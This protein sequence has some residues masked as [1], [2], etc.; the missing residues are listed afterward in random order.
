MPTLEDKEIKLERTRQWRIK[1]KSYISEYNKNYKKHNQD[2][3]KEY[4]Q[5][6]RE[7]NIESEKERSKKYHQTNPEVKRKS[8][9]KSR[10]LIS[11]EEYELLLKNQNYVCAICKEPESVKQKT[12]GLV[13]SLAV[14]HC[15]ISGKVRGLLCFRC[16]ATLGKIK[17]DKKLL[18]MMIK[19]LE[20]EK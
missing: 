9:R 8:I 20:S 2:S 3:I 4:N 18:K 1:N 16:N 7:N 13:K 10:Y 5:K 12:T 17:E 19:Y 11:N 15:H 6:Y 14:D